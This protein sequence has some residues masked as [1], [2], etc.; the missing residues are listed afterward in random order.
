MSQAAPPPG[1]GREDRATPHRL[2]AKVVRSEALP[3]EH[4][5]L[6]LR[7]PA[8]AADGEPGQFV[9]VW[10]HP[11]DDIEEPPSAALLRRPYSIS[12]L[13]GHDELELLLRVRGTGGR[14]LAAARAGDALDLIGPLG[15]GFRIREG[16]RSALVVAG[17]IGIAPMPFLVQALRAAR[18]E[19]ALLVG[20]ASD[21]ALPYP[22]TRTAP[23]RAGIPEFGALGADVSFVG[24][25][26]DGL[27]VSEVLEA[28]LGDLDPER[29]EVFACGPRAML[30]RIAEL[31]KGCVRTQVCLEERMACG[32]GACRSCVVPVRDDGGYRTVC[33][34]GPVF[35][36]D[37]IAWERLEP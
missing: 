31:T 5:R 18:V 15:R 27:L 16:L 7:A 36:A 28:R 21:G 20:A 6:A 23:G 1:D 29:D 9:H 35:P 25:A 24:E 4:H 34:D 32:L 14:M 10:C 2:R 8:V 19:V 26:T 12:R 33:R 30:S 3:G 17:G 22:V 37:E 13:T 11:P